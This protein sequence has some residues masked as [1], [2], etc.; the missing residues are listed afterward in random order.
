MAQIRAS[1]IAPLAALFGSMIIAISPLY[2]WV[3]EVGPFATAFYRFFLA[4]PVLLGWMVHEVSSHSTY[5]QPRTIKEFLLLFLAGIFLALDIGLWYLSITKTTIT[6]AVLLNNLSTVL[7][8]VFGCLW[9]GEKFSWNLVAGV[10]LALLGM[11]LLV[12]K[13]LQVNPDQWMGDG[14]ALISAFFYAGFILTTKFLR[15]YFSTAVIMVWAAFSCL[16]VFFGG[17]LLMGETMIP[18]TLSGWLIL[19]QLALLAHIVGQG[20]M[21]F[22]MGYISAT[23]SS[24]LSMVGPFVA[25]FLSWFLKGETL[26]PLQIA[27]GLIIIVGIILS[28][29]NKIIW[30]RKRGHP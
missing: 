30:K 4:L 26:T 12:G 27:G 22:S 11:G 5:R 16:Y 19:I 3:S 18:Q 2:V 24:L 8:A 25:A 21:S 13:P 7:V 6:N 9:L 20:L 1:L 29:Q 28:R 15:S 10:V 23:F 17:A 14:I